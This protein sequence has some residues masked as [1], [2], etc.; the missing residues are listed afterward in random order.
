MLLPDTEFT[1]E[2]QQALWNLAGRIVTIAMFPWMI[3][4]SLTMVTMQRDIAVM[5]SQVIHLPAEV[6]V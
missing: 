1:M 3:W 2:T 4:V 6:R 5:S